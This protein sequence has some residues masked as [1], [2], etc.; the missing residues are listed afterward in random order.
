M[1]AKKKNIT[2]EEWT[3]TAA[4]EPRIKHPLTSFF[5]FRNTSWEKYKD[6]SA[7]L[8][9]KELSKIIGEAWRNMGE[10]EKN[11]WKEL[12]GQDKERY[13]K[14]IELATL[15]KEKIERGEMLDDES[16]KADSSKSRN[17]GK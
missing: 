13:D 6:E 3:T 15:N 16:G 12:A 9:R 1:P 10:E 11:K 8:S 17:R 5:I 14:E 4:A 7:G 2:E